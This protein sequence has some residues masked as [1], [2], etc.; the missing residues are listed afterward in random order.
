[1]NI[2]FS[3][4]HPAQVHNYRVVREQLIKQGHQVFWLSSKK[5]IADY[6]LKAYGIE[7]T[8]LKRPKKGMLSKLITLLQNAWITMKVIHKNKVDFVVS[9]I[10]PGVV[11]GA[12][13][14]GKKQIGMTDTEQA[15]IYDKMFSK[16]V[17]AIIT[18]TSFERQLR[19]DQIRINANIEL[20]YLHPN[21]F[22][23]DRSEVYKLLNIPVGT[24]FVVVR[25]V[26][27]KAFHDEGIKF[28]TE[29]NKV[30]V[31]E[32]MRKYAEV[33][34]SSEDE[35]PPQLQPY[36][37]RFPYEK[38]HEVMKEAALLYGE[39]ATMASECAIM[40]TPSIYVNAQPRGYTNDEQRHGLLWY[41][42]TDEASQEAS[43]EKAVELL[44]NKDQKEA[45]EQNHRKFMESKIDPVAF[46]IWFIENYPE[47]KRIMT[48]T[49]D[50]QCQFK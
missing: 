32:S 25:F 23:Y 14:M 50:Y 30:K 11:L 22:K 2:L 13:L 18:S 8:Q 37:I 31:V 3:T 40:G 4:G 17:S 41:F 49:P 15:G 21:Y 34:I 35:L 5:D 16:L 12:W 26:G 39:S 20:F 10:N 7:Y 36:K 48:E 47:S 9:R 27:T 45:F 43:I 29:A 44:R 1:M 38:V 42:K 33:F 6:L 28:I 19:K 24:P 46:L